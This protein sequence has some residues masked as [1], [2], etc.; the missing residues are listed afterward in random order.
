[1]PGPGRHGKTSLHLPD[2]PLEFDSQDYEDE[3]RRRLTD[4]ATS[5][6][7]DYCDPNFKA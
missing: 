1:M 5:K 3:L 2:G 6:F 4:V 7:Q